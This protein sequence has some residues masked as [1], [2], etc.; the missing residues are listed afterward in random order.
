MPDHSKLGLPQGIRAC[1]FDMDG[2]LTD[3]ASVHRAAWKH[4]FDDFLRDRDGTGFRPFTLADY[5]RYVDGKPRADGTRDFLAS[6]D[7][8][9]PEGSPDDPPGAPTVQGLSRR[10]NDLVQEHL[11][12]DGVTVFDGSVRYLDAVRAAG[13][14]VAVVSA[15]ENTAAVLEQAGIADRFDARID[16]FVAK[17]RGLAGKPAPDT[18]LAGAA[19][20]GAEPAASAV[21]EDAIAGVQAGRAGRFGYV[22]GVDRVDHA[23]ALRSGGADIVVMDLAELLE[24]ER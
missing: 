12:T 13:L 19:A 24:G 1:L 16:G 9:L 6:R 22:V 23:A 2:V 17:E 10:K 15:S 7:I 8:R 14:R 18:Y 3:T 20:V 4:M 5:N 21:F 11:R